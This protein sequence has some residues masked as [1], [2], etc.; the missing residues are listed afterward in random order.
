MADIWVKIEKSK[1][2]IIIPKIL[3]QKD[4]EEVVNKKNDKDL[5]MELFILIMIR[6]NNKYLAIGYKF[7]GDR[8]VYNE[9]WYEMTKLPI[10]D[11]L[12]KIKIKKN[13]I[14]G[15]KL[16]NSEVRENQV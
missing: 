16:N 12:K 2:F 13:K 8:I 9:I 15:V 6:R 7:I 4:N 14:D 5:C 11:D 3:L 1:T 10:S